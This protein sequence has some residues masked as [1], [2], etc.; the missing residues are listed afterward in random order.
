[1]SKY[2]SLPYK[3]AWQYLNSYERLYFWEK[4]QEFSY[5]NLR[6]LIDI[7]SFM[8]YG[9]LHIYIFYVL[10]MALIYVKLKKVIQ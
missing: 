3:K 2:L 6:S 1:M 4:S 10:R 8:F 7:H 9:H 5:L